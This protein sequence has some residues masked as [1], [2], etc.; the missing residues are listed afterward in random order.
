MFLKQ[1]EGNIYNIDESKN[2]EDTKKYL[3]SFISKT[4]IL[5]NKILKDGSVELATYSQN[6]SGAKN[7]LSF[8]LANLKDDITFKHTDKVFANKIWSSSMFKICFNNDDFK[9]KQFK[10]YDDMMIFH[11]LY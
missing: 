5:K 8:V 2:K 7:I 6:A 4:K 10:S 11:F 3:L 1:G 9:T